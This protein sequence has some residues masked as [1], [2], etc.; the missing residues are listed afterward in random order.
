MALKFLSP[1]TTSDAEAK[2]KSEDAVLLPPMAVVPA[3]A[4]TLK[5]VTV[6]HSKTPG[7]SASNLLH[8]LPAL[9]LKLSTVIK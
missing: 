9:F 8:L 7:G 3:R 5:S 4:F 1:D 2:C 6:V